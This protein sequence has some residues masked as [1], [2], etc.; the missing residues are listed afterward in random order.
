MTVWIYIAREKADERWFAKHDPEA[1]AVEYLCCSIFALGMS[2][3]ATNVPLAWWHPSRLALKVLGF[4]IVAVLSQIV[5][6][7]PKSVSCLD[8]VRVVW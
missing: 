1:Q 4:F 5:A 6:P 7:P 2:G 3:P 8:A